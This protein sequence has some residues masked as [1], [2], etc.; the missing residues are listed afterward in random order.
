[1]IAQLR[2]DGIL[3]LKIQ[4]ADSYEVTDDNGVEIF[5]NPGQVKDLRKEMAR[6][7]RVP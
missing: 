1:M 7:G 6:A 4:D 5:L 3:Y 2:P